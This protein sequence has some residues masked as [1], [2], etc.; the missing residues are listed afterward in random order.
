ATLAAGFSAPQAVIERAKSKDNASA[1]TF[2]IIS[3]LLIK[4]LLGFVIKFDVKKE[5]GFKSREAS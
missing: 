2:F 4:L 1:V 5:K 3:S